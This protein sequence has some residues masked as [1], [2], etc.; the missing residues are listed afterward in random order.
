MASEASN[1]EQKQKDESEFQS[2]LNQAQKGGKKD[3]FGKRQSRFVGAEKKQ[4]WWDE[5]NNPYRQ[6]TAQNSVGGQVTGPIVSG[7]AEEQKGQIAG[8]NIAN[9]G[10]GQGLSGVGSDIQRVKELQ[11]ARTEG[12]DPVSEAIRNQKAGNI[13]ST[14]RNLAASGVKGGVAAGALDEVARRQDADIAASLYG[15]QAQSIGAERSL[16]SNMLAGTTAL[17]QGGKAEGTAANMPKAPETSGAFGTVICT[18]LYK[19]G[20]YTNELYMRDIAYGAWVRST[21]PEVYVGY[22]MWADYVVSGMQKSKLFTKVVALLAVPWA[23]NMAGESNKLG[24]F[25]SF[26]GEPICS[27]I[28]TFTIKLGAK[29]VRG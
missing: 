25:I 11:R 27:I 23:K 18:E 28:G 3:L 15:Q 21:K 8:L 14:Q 7:T 26:I 19:Q 9:I 16:A 29:Y 12:S 17:M 13:A 5:R 6:Q 10:Y 24:A 2:W 4:A 20:Y 1:A 22:R